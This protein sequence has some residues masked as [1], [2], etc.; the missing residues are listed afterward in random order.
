[1]KKEYVLVILYIYSRLLVC[2]CTYTIGNMD[3]SFSKCKLVRSIIV[4]LSKKTSQKPSCMDYDSPMFFLPFRAMGCLQ[5]IT[6]SQGACAPRTDSCENELR[7]S[8][9]HADMPDHTTTNACKRYRG[10]LH[11]QL[12][13]NSM[14]LQPVQDRSSW[15]DSHTTEQSLNR[16]IYRSYMGHWYRSCNNSNHW[17]FFLFLAQYWKPQ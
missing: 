6:S 13:V 12:C 7:D 16:V 1:M 3:I 15:C 11:I 8:F 2:S 4:P 10:P 5:L 14:Y 9:W 17:R